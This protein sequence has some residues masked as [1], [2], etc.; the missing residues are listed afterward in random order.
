MRTESA[1]D[2]NTQSSY[3]EGA[4]GCNYHKEAL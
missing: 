2:R 3:R 1:K 4:A